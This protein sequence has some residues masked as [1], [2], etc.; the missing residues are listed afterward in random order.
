[1]ILMG[2]PPGLALLF[3]IAAVVSP[4]GS[5][6]CKPGPAM[7]RILALCTIWGLLSPR[8]VGTRLGGA[9]R[10]PACAGADPSID[11]ANENPARQSRAGQDDAF[12]RR[13]TAQ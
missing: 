9:P 2:I 12:S 5:L 6:Q 13:R 11:H 1:L 3:E 8:H 4:R 10:T 7:G